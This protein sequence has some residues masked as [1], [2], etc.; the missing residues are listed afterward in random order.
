MPNPSQKS[1]PGIAQA[2]VEVGSTFVTGGQI[3]LIIYALL[4]IILM[5]LVFLFLKEWLNQRAAGVAATALKDATAAIQGLNVQVARL[6]STNGQLL[7]LLLQ[8]RSE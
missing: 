5:L 6:E 7:S 3:G 4:L 2:A 1:D 8:E